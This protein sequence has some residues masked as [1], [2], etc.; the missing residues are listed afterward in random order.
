MITGLLVILKENNKKCF[1]TFLAVGSSNECLWPQ[2]QQT[3]TNCELKFPLFPNKVISVLNIV[4]FL[5]LLHSQSRS[6]KN[7]AYMCQNRKNKS[8]RTQVYWAAH[9]FHILTVIAPLHCFSPS[10]SQSPRIWGEIILNL[11]PNTKI[12]VITFWLRDICAVFCNTNI[13]SYSL[14]DKLFWTRISRNINW[15]TIKGRGSKQQN[16]NF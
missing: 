1:H 15:V 14:S 16:G 10:I 8:Y 6:Q 2:N 12:E 3:C 5:C 7:I 9:L 11:Q 13:I 4:F